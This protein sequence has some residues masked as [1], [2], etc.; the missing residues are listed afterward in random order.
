MSRIKEHGE[1]FFPFVPD[2]DSVCGP[3]SGLTAGP[4]TGPLT[5][6]TAE[7]L[8]RELVPFGPQYQTLRETLYLSEFEAW[9][10][11][12]APNLP[13]APIEKIIGSPFPL[14]GAFHAACVLGQQFVDFVPFPVGFDK[15][16]ITRPTQAGCSYQTKVKY[17]CQISEELVFDLAIFDSEGQLYET[18]TGLRM[19]DVR[20]AV[21]R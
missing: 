15:R 1:V 16:L 12:Q 14:D 17:V 6:I 4:L 18:T 5:E 3:F 11:L 2:G 13:Q 10:K 21:R 9:S 7:Y 20:A 8:Y 19:R